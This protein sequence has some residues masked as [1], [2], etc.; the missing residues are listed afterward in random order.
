[1][2]MLNDIDYDIIESA[3]D[4]YR[5][6]LDDLKADVMLQEELFKFGAMYM[7]LEEAVA[8]GKL[9]K[10]PSQNQ[11]KDY[12]DYLPNVNEMTEEEIEEYNNRLVDYMIERSENPK[13]PVFDDFKTT[14]DSL[15]K[16]LGHVADKLAR[17]DATNPIV[18]YDTLCS[19]KYNFDSQCYGFR[20][21]Q[22]A[23]ASDLLSRGMMIV[24]LHEKVM[25][26]PK[27]ATFFNLQKRV[28]KA[29]KFLDESYNLIGQPASDIKKGYSP[30][31]YVLGKKVLLRYSKE[32]PSCS[33]YGGAI[34]YYA[35]NRNWSDDEKRILMERIQA[36]NI[37]EE[38][39]A[40]GLDVGNALLLS[41]SRSDL[42]TVY[43][44]HRE[45]DRYY[46]YRG[47][48]I[49]K[50]KKTLAKASL[51][52]KYIERASGE[53]IDNKYKEVTLLTLT[54]YDYDP[55]LTVLDSENPSIGYQA[56]IENAGWL[57]SVISKGND[58]ATAGTTGNKKRMEALK[59]FL[60]DSNGDSVLEY[61]GYVESKGW[62][63][64]RD[65][66]TDN[67]AG[68]TEQSKRMEGIQ[69]RLK[70]KYADKYD[71]VYR[72][73]MQDA[74]WGEWV[75]NGEISGLVGKGKRME[76]IEIKLV[77]KK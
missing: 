60:V 42:H 43:Y 71:V 9:D 46:D 69:I 26:Y 58:V 8:E 48:I 7:A 22:R 52:K 74:G 50:D 62:Q 32:H 72:T 31:S 30:F 53:L 67:F 17:A 12:E 34:K 20:F 21:A 54:D 57:P 24:F 61:C 45:Y 6:N 59:I 75:K 4:T 5:E 63:V 41:F 44:G 35:G 18:R 56:Y 29:A 55:K 70:Y 1:M 36:N 47:E 38:F 19:M 25:T 76:A 10:V 27:E 49:E 23:T 3:N 33:D 40:A 66:S 16:N 51:G 73:H 2:D 39:A 37:K 14:Y 13:D 77:K 68:T 11:F 65:S 28:E 64:W 15:K